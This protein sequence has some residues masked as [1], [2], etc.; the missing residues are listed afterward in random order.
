[1]FW[2]LYFFFHGDM[3]FSGVTSSYIHLHTCD[4]QCCTEVLYYGKE[5]DKDVIVDGMK[6]AQNIYQ[7]V[8]SLKSPEAPPKTFSA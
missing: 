8:L 4:C 5:L 1:M 3:L 2:F 6:K 7:K